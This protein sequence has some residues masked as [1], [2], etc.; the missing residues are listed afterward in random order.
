ME[1]L[2]KQNIQARI[3]SSL[4]NQLMLAGELPLLVSQYPTG[5]EEFKKAAAPIDCRANRS[6]SLSPDYSLASND[7]GTSPPDRRQW[8]STLRWP[9]NLLI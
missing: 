1:A 2:S 9:A 3:G 7:Q 8:T 6:S 4:M 5:V